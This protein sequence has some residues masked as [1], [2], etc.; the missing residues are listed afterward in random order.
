MQ[1]CLGRGQPGKALK[2]FAGGKTSMG[3]PS[4]CGM[5]QMVLVMSKYMV[6]KWERKRSRTAH[7]L[8]TE[9]VRSRVMGEVCL[10]PGS[11]VLEQP[12]SDQLPGTMLVPMCNA[13]ARAP[14]I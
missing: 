12:E 10:P 3:P 2:V 5:G 8:W 7:V 6:K 13:V 9:A 1:F 11:L 4:A 14:E